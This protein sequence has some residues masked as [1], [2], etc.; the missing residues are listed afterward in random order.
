MA[1]GVAASRVALAFLASGSDAE[2][3]VCGARLSRPVDDDGGGAWREPPT[4]DGATPVDAA[5]AAVG[6]GPG[7]FLKKLVMAPFSL[8]TSLVTLGRT[9]R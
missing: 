8:T 7:S 1:N 9:T 2:P 4:P 5:A 6:A 3:S